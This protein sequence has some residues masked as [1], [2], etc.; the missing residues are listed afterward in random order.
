MTLGTVIALFGASMCTILPG[1]GSILGVQ[2]CGKAAAGVTSEKPEL[3]GKLLVL[4]I[5]PGTQGLY[6]F[7]TTFLFMI[8]TGVLAGNAEAFQ[9]TMEQGWAYFA[10]FTPIAINGLISAI[11][12]GRVATAGIMMTSKQPD[13][14]GKG[15]TMA[16]LVETYAIL[17]LIVSIMLIFSL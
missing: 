16:V 11:F 14:S 4:Q 1:I 10:V 9:L 8:Q 13:A 7:L 2:T 6:G 3:F 15:I 5:L 17:S 12:Q